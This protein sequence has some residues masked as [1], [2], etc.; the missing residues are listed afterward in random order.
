MLDHAAVTREL[1]EKIQVV[2]FELL[3]WGQKHPE[4]RIMAEELADLII[5]LHGELE[6][7]YRG[8]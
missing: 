8:R 6:K 2:E 3:K 4:F 7:Y 1:R 5:H